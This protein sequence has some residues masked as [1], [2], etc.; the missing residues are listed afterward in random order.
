M[1]PNEKKLQIAARVQADEF[2]QAVRNIII[3]LLVH[4]SAAPG[5]KKLAYSL[6]L[7]E[8]CVKVGMSTLHTATCND[9][10][11]AEGRYEYG[12]ARGSQLF[13]E[14]IDSIREE[15]KE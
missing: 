11:V 12:T 14:E 2:G 13:N 7:A 5:P 4:N 6:A 9:L 15:L 1:T 10:T 3:Q 8:E